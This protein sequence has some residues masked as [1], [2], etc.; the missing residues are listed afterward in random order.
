MS[1]KRKERRYIR[2]GG[3]GGMFSNCLILYIFKSRGKH[4][5][6]NKQTSLALRDFVSPVT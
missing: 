1:I 3:G 6:P 5:L 4:S 2:E